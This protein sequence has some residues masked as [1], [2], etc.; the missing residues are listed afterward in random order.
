MQRDR[1]IT[2]ILRNTPHGEGSGPLHLSEACAARTADK[3]PQGGFTR[4]NRQFICGSPRG[5]R[6]LHTLGFAA[7]PT[8]L[9]STRYAGANLAGRYAA[10]CVL[11]NSGSAWSSVTSCN[12]HPPGNF[13]TQGPDPVRL[14]RIA[15]MR[16]GTELVWRDE[17]RQHTIAWCRMGERRRRIL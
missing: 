7:C 10:V 11:A 6:R 15:F 13:S 9:L 14:T 8:V 3:F 4:F 12:A 17:R 2:Q 16:A 5:I 1:S